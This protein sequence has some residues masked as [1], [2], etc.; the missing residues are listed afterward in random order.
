MKKHL[1]SIREVLNWWHDGLLTDKE[2]AAKI[3]AQ[4][5]MMVMDNLKEVPNEKT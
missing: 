2:A 4:V 5:F 3:L 1:Y